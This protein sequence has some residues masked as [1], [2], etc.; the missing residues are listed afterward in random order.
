M[1]TPAKIASTSKWRTSRT[2]IFA[3]LNGTRLPSVHTLSALVA[4]WHP[5]GEDAVA[6][7]MLKLN[8]VKQQLSAQQRGPLARTEVVKADVGNVEPSRTPVRRGIAVPVD[9][10]ASWV[11]FH[12]ELRRLYSDAGRPSLAELYKRTTIPRS[13]LSSWLAGKVIPPPDRLQVLLRG[14]GAA[15][16]E[17]NLEMMRRVVV[18]DL[19]V[20]RQQH[21]GG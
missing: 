19:A 17:A 14:L 6:E 2:A 12:D 4:A 20:Q 11:D 7:W 3:A 16:H 15:D 10:P 9:V 8:E 18:L 21:R 5:R 13:T 1:L